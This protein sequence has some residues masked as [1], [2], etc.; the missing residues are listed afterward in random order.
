VA[1][2]FFGDRS[3][4]LHLNV[5]GEHLSA[6]SAKPQTLSPDYLRGAMRA[7]N[8]T[9][10]QGSGGRGSK[11]V[12]LFLLRDYVVP[13]AA[14]ANTSGKASN[15]RSPNFY[16]QTSFSAASPISDVLVT[17]DVVTILNNVFRFSNGTTWLLL[18][19]SSD[20]AQ[21]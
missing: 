15:P 20:P 10:A 12:G 8:T 1:E 14:G 3:P 17:D 18:R 2:V 5:A 4:N 7:R 9:T 16:R 11:F 19:C 6:T 21:W 13:Q